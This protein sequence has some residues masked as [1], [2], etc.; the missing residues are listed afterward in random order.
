[1][2]EKRITPFAGFTPQTISFLR[3]LKENNNKQWFEEHRT[4]Y[5]NELLHPFRA[6]I[7]MIS[8][9]MYSIDPRFEMRPNRILS[10]IYRDIRFSQ[11]KDPYKSSMWMSFQRSGTQWE[12][13]PGYFMELN[14]EDC[15]YGLGLFMPKRKV[16]DRF[17][18]EVEF[19]PESFR[20]MMEKKVLQ[21]GFVIE[22]EKYKR[23]L[24]I[25]LPD[26]YQQWIQRKNFYVIKTLPL[27]DERIYSEA[28]A[29]LLMDD[30]TQLADLYHFL[31]EITEETE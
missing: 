20:E 11:N 21:R 4:I 1:M 25:N 7:G 24:P 10:R 27:N 23:P 26:M 12:Y 5:E 14:T 29:L 18:E 8:P 30:F 3:E 16:M 17:R 28:L 22:G 15:C 31:V 9:A 13:F 19:Q 6:L 2:E